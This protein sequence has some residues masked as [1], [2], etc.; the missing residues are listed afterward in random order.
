MPVEDI[1]W[2]QLLFGVA[3]AVFSIGWAVIAWYVAEAVHV[4]RRR[5]ALAEKEADWMS[6]RLRSTESLVDIWERSINQ[7]SHQLRE[8]EGALGKASH[9]MNELKRALDASLS[10]LRELRETR[11]PLGVAL[12]RFS[13]QN[14]GTEGL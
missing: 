3:S 2:L 14:E 5:L 8:K 11:D 4:Y 10:A 1:D 7:V 12:N 9:E 6:Q 13:G